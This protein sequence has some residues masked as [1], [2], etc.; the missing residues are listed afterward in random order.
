MGSQLR[1]SIAA[2]TTEPVTLVADLPITGKTTNLASAA[3]SA[4]TA[5]LPAGLYR[6]TSTID[7]AICAGDT[8][9]ATDMSIFA[10]SVEYFY[11]PG[12]KLAA[13]CAATGGT[14][15]ATLV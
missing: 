13:Y 6:I 5:T 4:A 1:A 14:I 9:A 11:I 8:A 12:T 2:G 10:G 3:G 15:K 7:A